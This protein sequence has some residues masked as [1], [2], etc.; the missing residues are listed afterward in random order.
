[1]FPA[2]QTDGQCGSSTACHASGGNL[3]V[4]LNGNATGT[5]NS[6]SQYTQLENKPYIKM[7]DTNPADSTIDCS[8][9]TQTCQTLTP[10]PTS[11]PANWT[12]TDKQLI[13]TWVLC[14]AP[15]N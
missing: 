6:F 7:G 3:P 13:Q 14:G 2:L 9:D 15:N 11:P 12:A 8:L 4:F 5:Y 1:M 10:M